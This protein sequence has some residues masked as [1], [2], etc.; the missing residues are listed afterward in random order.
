MK[1]RINT[2]RGHTLLELLVAMFVM[3]ILVAAALPFYGQYIVKGKIESIR[4]TLFLTA[5]AEDRYF[6]LH[7]Q[8]ATI[9]Q[10]V[11]EGFMGDIIS[12]LPHNI[13]LDDISLVAVPALTE[14]QGWSYALLMAADVDKNPEGQG[15]CLAYFS[16]N[17]PSGYT[18]E[19]IVLYDDVANTSVA[20]SA[21]L[22][23]ASCPGVANCTIT[24]D[25]GPGGGGGTGGTGD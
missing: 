5:A 2:V 22:N 9:P 13:T 4:E 8:Y 18:G 12:S 17:H 23:C 15:Q 11:D 16:T 3:G 20:P 25:S 6:A 1:M 10:L 7:K 21:Y 19:I 14:L 24:S